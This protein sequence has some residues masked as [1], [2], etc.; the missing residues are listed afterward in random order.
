MYMYQ[1]VDVGRK[2]YAL[3]SMLL[4]TKLFVKRYLK[5]DRLFMDTSLPQ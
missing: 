3:I 2:I 5:R 4:M 1:D